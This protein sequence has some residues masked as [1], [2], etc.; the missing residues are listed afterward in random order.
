MGGPGLT[1][2]SM[3]TARAARWQLLIGGGLDGFRQIEETS[4][5]FPLCRT[6]AARKIV[7]CRVMHQCDRSADR[8]A[9]RC[10]GQ[11]PVALAICVG[12]C[13]RWNALRDQ[14]RGKGYTDDTANWSKGLRPQSPPAR[15]RSSASTSVPDRSNPISAIANAA[16]FSPGP[17]WDP[18]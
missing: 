3:V 9:V 14:V 17:A 18:A 8:L 13:A 2:R 10:S 4:P 6:A 7:R 16:A 5:P 12:G 11:L 1:T 15:T